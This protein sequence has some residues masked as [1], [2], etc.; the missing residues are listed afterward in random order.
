MAPLRPP[1]RQEVLRVSEVACTPA[2]FELRPPGCAV[3]ILVDS[4][5][6]QSFRITKSGDDG[7]PKRVT[8]TETP[9]IP[10]GEEY[11]W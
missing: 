7:N 9:F 3:R 8:V 1:V 2:K 11:V 4:G 10:A 5:P 6:K